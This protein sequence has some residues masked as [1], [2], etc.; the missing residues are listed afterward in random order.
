M[1]PDVLYGWVS[2][3]EEI[4]DYYSKW[5]SPMEK[6]ATAPA[7]YGEVSKDKRKRRDLLRALPATAATLAGAAAFKKFRGT[8][9]LLKNLLLYSGTGA[10]TG[11]LPL[12]YRDAYRTLR[13]RR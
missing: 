6:Q 12:V 7:M 2:E 9:G 8:K 4:E 10:T 3:M 5:G 11:W 1:T 13:D